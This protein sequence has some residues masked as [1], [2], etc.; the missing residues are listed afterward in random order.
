MNLSGPRR[1]WHIGLMLVDFQVDQIIF[2]INWQD[3][4]MIEYAV[5]FATIFLFLDP[6]SN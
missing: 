6:S 2:N 5:K 3:K 1:P 4:C